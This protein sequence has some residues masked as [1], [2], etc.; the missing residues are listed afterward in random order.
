M[1]EFFELSLLIA[2]VVT[3]TGLLIAGVIEVAL[4]AGPWPS[5][6]QSSR[7]ALHDSNS[8]TSTHRASARHERR[9]L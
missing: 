4:R 1:T 2:L 8:T 3:V 6:A 9:M 7:G 5:S